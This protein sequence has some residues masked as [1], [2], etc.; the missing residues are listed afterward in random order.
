M[1]C[2]LAVGLGY[3]GISAYQYWE[4]YHDRPL[5]AKFTYIGR[6]YQSG[7]QGVVLCGGA[8]NEAY[9]YATDVSESNIVTEFEGWEKDRTAEWSPGNPLGVSG[10]GNKSRKFNCINMVRTGSAVVR[11]AFI[12]YAINPQYEYDT[13]NLK[14]IHKKYLLRINNQGWGDTYAQLVSN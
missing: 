12:C 10:Q 3:C 6:D 7:C 9:Y 2:I 8:R 5:G 14:P 13:Y 1:V 4:N 11:R